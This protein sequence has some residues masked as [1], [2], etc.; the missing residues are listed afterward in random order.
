[1]QKG[2]VREFH[3]TLVE[4]PSSM[5]YHA[6]IPFEVVRREFLNQLLSSALVTAIFE[7]GTVVIFDSVERVDRHESEVLSCITPCRCKQLIYEEGGGDDCGPAV[8]SKSILFIY[9]SPTAELVPRF[10]KVNL[11]SAILKPDRCG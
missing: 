7:P 2:L 6:P 3:K 1:M 8:K 4:Y 5:S 9:I 11:D 10:K